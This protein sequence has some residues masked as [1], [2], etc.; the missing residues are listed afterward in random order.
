MPF[1]LGQ[2]PHPSFR[3]LSLDDGLILLLR[4][5]CKPPGAWDCSVHQ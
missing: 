5:G 1:L 2:L 3:T 4:K